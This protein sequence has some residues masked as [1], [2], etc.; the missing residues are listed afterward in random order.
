AA[1]GAPAGSDTGLGLAPGTPSVATMPGGFAPA[2]GVKSQDE[3]DYR[4]DF[5][6]LITMPLRLGLNKPAGTATTQPQT[7]V[8]HAPP[9][10]PDYPDSFVYTTVVPQPYAQ[11]AFSYGN[12]VVTATTVLKAWTATTAQSFFDPTLQGGI[13][14][15]FITFNLPGLAK[16]MHLGIN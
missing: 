2:Y 3:Q 7:T 10:V 16:G 1:D 8:I 15:A 13:T 5:H 6:G 12:S 4:V 11:L 9:V 14:D